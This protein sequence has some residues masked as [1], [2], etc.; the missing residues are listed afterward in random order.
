M[1]ARVSFGLAALCLL[2]GFVLPLWFTRMEAPQ[3]KGDEALGVRVYANRVEG[4]LG[5]IRLL[6]GY[7]GVELPEEF[8]ELEFVPWALGLLL[9]LAAGG[10]VVRDRFRLWVGTGLLIAFVGCA[11]GGTLILQRRL[12]ALGHERG[13]SAFARIDDFMPPLFGSAKIAN[14]MVSTGLDWGG[15]SLACAFGL[16]ACGVFLAFR[17]RKR[18][19]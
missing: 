10:S 14:F 2:L 5:E 13:A 18:R 1:M 4:D 7:V 12:Y 8:E 11:I 15:W 9:L 6:N 3:Y 17:H 16:S 19:Q